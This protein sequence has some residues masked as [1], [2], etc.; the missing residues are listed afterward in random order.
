MQAADASAEGGRLAVSTWTVKVKVFQFKVTPWN[1]DIPNTVS[2]IRCVL[3]KWDF[4]NI[5]VNMK[6]RGVFDE[7][8]TATFLDTWAYMCDRWCRCQYILPLTEIYSYIFSKLYQATLLVSVLRRWVGHLLIPWKFQ[9]LR[10][11]IVLRP[12]IYIL[13]L[14]TTETIWFSL[15]IQWHIS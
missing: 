1:F 5:H 7:A 14:Q 13:T 10:I 11:Q 9:S 12:K 15:C 8:I 2:W 3:Q 6:N 4:L